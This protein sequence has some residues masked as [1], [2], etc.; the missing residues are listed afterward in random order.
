MHT[1]PIV[2]KGSSCTD[3]LG[4]MPGGN[5]PVPGYSAQPGRSSVNGNRRT[6]SQ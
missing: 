1:R 3:L 6:S 4:S 5:V 2:G